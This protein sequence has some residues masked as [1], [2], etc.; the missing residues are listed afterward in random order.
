MTN[1]AGPLC[2]KCGRR[3]A[4]W[5]LDHCVYCGQVFPEGFRDGFAEPEALKWIERP[6]IPP[7]AARQLE[8]MKLV[9]LEKEKK[10]RFVMG[11]ALLSIPIFGT[12]FFLLY[13]LVRRYSPASA[14]LVLVAG[15]GFLAYLF[16]SLTKKT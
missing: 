11:L 8:M 14:V 13:S 1:P 10:P 15:F 5:R 12:I 2:P 4:A 6:S 9:P 16:W 7:E 3:I